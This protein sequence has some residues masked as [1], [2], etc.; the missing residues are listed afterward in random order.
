M[1]NIGEKMLN[2][3]QSLVMENLVTEVVKGEDPYKLVTSNLIPMASVKRAANS[4]IYVFKEC[5]TA[6]GA[7]KIFLNRDKEETDVLKVEF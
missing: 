1:A 4:T 5:M 7:G 2:L 3:Q 6:E